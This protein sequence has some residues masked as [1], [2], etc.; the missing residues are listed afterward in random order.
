MG[1]H[2]PGTRRIALETSPPPALSPNERM[3]AKSR[4]AVVL[5]DRLD[6][7]LDINT[8]GQVKLHQRLNGLGVRLQHIDEASMSTDFELLA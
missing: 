3:F 2:V 4:Q 8:S 1:L 7:D 6:L 5:R